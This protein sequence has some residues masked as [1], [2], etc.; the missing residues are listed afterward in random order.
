MP[1]LITTIHPLHPAD[2]PTT[3]GN[4]SAASGNSGYRFR[5]TPRPA[6]ELIRRCHQFAEAEIA[7]W[8]RYEIA[9][10]HLADEQDTDLDWDGYRWITAT[11]ATTSGG[12]QAK[13][14]ALS[15]SA[16]QM[17]FNDDPEDADR[18]VAISRPA[19]D[20]GARPA[21]PSWL[22]RPAFRAVAG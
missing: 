13:V 8:Y 11:P 9:P 15:A 10:V 20:S 2:A 17:Y 19:G 6:G 5:P 21:T 4:A 12:W 18:G 7:R 14:L 1:R 16:P 3:C 22:A